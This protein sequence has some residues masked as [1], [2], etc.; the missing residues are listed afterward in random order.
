MLSGCCG[1]QFVHCYFKD[2]E[3]LVLVLAAMFWVSFPE[4]YM[5]YYHTFQAG[6]WTVVDTGPFLGRAIVWKLM[7]ALTRL[8]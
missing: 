4:F 8:A 7:Y 3:E 2:T 1:I 5:K 6:K